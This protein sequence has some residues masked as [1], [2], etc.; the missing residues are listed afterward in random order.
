V[1]CATFQRRRRIMASPT[2]SITTVVVSSPFLE[3]IPE[4]SLLLLYKCFYEGGAKTLTDA[5]HRKKPENPAFWKA[6]KKIL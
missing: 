6:K 2:T 5:K 4:F 3:S 1:A